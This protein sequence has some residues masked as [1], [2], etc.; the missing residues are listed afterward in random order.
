[1]PFDATIADR[2]R[3]LMARRAGFAEKKMF[4][5]VGYLLDGNMCVGVW[6]E[7]LIVR[8]GP[9]AYEDALAK[10]GVQEFDITGRP[11]KG[12]VMVDPSG[13]RGDIELAQWVEQAV[14]FVRML[15]RK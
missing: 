10:R 8:V 1:M 7:F 2:V 6:K 11:M 3:P 9:E 12:W 5:G 13:V 4:G 14:S 15:P